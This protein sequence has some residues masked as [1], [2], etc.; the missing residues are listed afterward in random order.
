MMSVERGASRLLGALDLPGVATSAATARR[1]VSTLLEKSGFGRIDDAVLLVSEL[2]S[3]AVLH[4]ESGRRSDGRLLMT[5]SMVSA[6][7]MPMTSARNQ[8]TSSQ[9]LQSAQPSHAAQGTQ[10][11]QPARAIQTAQAAQATQAP[12]AAQAIGAAA[13]D[14]AAQTVQPLQAVQV[15]VIDEGSAAGKPELRAT[16]DGC[17]GRGLWLVEQIAATWGYHDDH[18]GRVVWFELR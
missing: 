10:A 2:V 3:N 12:Q 6:M 16:P 8:A 13:P 9:R 11:R 14:P 17:G 15:E 1:Y 18:R 5:V 7:S 4:S